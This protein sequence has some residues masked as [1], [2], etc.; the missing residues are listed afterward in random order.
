MRHR[1]TAGLALPLAGAPD[2][3]VHDAPPPRRVA[4]VADDYPGLKARLRVEVGAAVTAGDPIIDDR[5]SGVVLRSP[6][7]GSVRAINR[8]QRR[9]LRSVEIDVEPDG[10]RTYGSISCS[11]ADVKRL[12]I[13]CGLWT[14]LRTRPFSKIPSPQGRLPNALF[15]TAMDSAPLAPSM[16]VIC[17][18]RDGDMKAGVEA[19]C[20]LTDGPTYVCR[21]PGSTIGDN[22]DC[23]E[24][25]E[26][27]GPHPAGTVGLH[28]HHLAPVNRAFCAWHIGLQDVLAIGRLMRTGALVAERI[29]SVA[30]PLVMQPRL[31]R[32][33]LG[34]AV[35]PLVDGEL[36]D[37]PA[38]V[39]SGSVL[40]GRKVADDACG[41]LGR[42]HQQITVIEEAEERE[43]F[44]WAAPG[45]RKFSALNVVLSR[46]L[47]K[48]NFAF[49]TTTNGGARAMMPI[50]TYER[51]MPMDIV[52]TYLLRAL[53]CDDLD[54]AEALGCLE[55]D[56]EDLALCTYVC[57]GKNDYGPH[58]R[59]VLDAIERE[60]S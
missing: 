56:E 19:L 46:L 8:G 60:M 22:V 51:V 40:L 13:D 41:Y 14:A 39:I 21:A 2:Q 1:I 37:R 48:R 36:D 12:L 23:I 43:M 59:R 45:R 35:H 32:T 47:P 24:V 30:G 31:L 27:D 15:V 29:V 11:R 33:Q 44:G 26:F 52:A 28:I 54:R 20:T 16:D 53:V 9:R 57:P 18:G 25:H 4:L 7:T 10:G 38:R 34:A 58:L 50:G 6:A 42:Y 17:A 5:Q 49:T 55:L 3:S